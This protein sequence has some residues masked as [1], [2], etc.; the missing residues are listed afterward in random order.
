M[1]D[2]TL[3][4]LHLIGKKFNQL[5]VIDVAPHQKGR[6]H[7]LCKCDCG[8]IKSIRKDCL[9]SGGTPSCGC[10][11]KLKYYDKRIKK[12]FEEFIGNKYGLL[13]VLSHS[14][15]KNHNPY[16]LCLC[17]CGKEANV[18]KDC[19]IDGNTQSCG[20]LWLKN[21]HSRT[22]GA[23]HGDG[24]RPE[25]KVWTGMKQRCLNPN[26][27]GYKHWGGRGIK[28]CDKWLTF[29]GFIEDM[30][31]RPSDKHSID[32]INNDGNYEK[33]NCRWATRKEQ[34]ENQRRRGKSKLTVTK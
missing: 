34:S 26:A 16:F 10:T 25:Y 8:N 22:H 5:T 29:E 27:Y 28:V 1:P 31:K 19:L 21:C 3:K 24:Y 33:L 30:G 2:A 17:D 12:T 4:Y 14:F 23:S 15:T 7:I 9:L 13:T 6:A 11:R 20:C 32:R 18:R